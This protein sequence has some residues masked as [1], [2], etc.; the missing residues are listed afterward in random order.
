VVLCAAGLTGTALE[1][2][3]QAGSVGVSTLGLG[4][5]QVNSSATATQSG[6]AI[7]TPGFSTAGWLGVTP[8]DA[9]A[10]G[11][12]VAA[13]V[14]NNACPNVFFS[15]NMKTCFG[16]MSKIGAD[17]IAQFSVPWW[18]RTDFTPNLTAGQ[19]AKLIVNGVVGQADVWVN[20]TRVATQST[21]Q[22]A[23]TRY[24]F[25][26]T[27]L[28]RAGTTR[29]PSR[30][31]RTTRPRC[32]RWTMWTGRRSRRTTTPASSSRSSSRS[33]RRS[34]WAASTWWRTTPPT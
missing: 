13:L 20:G 30:S 21:V 7:S 28:L 24:T 31:I 12:E 19:N 3:A 11:T 34:H 4:G 23:F 9:G 17:T 29:W 2:P 10:P 8:D 6:S 16:Y 26:V 14:Q 15:T 1:R 32:S 5:W 25:D 22:G 18:F 33:P 27:S